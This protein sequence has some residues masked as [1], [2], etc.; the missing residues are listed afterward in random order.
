MTPH[1]SASA[2]RRPSVAWTLWL[3]SLLACSNSD[4]PTLHVQ[5]TIANWKA[6]GA[7]ILWLK[8]A[9]TDDKLADGSVTTNG[10]FQL[11]LPALGSVYMR[12]QIETGAY[13]DP[14]GPNSTTPISYSDPLYT[15]GF[16]VFDYVT[17]GNYTSYNVGSL[18][19]LSYDPR[20]P[21]PASWQSAT[22]RYFT[23]DVTISG[24][25]APYGDPIHVNL[26]F[27]SGWNLEVTQYDATSKTTTLSTVDP[28]GQPAGLQ[29][30]EFP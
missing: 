5:G 8:D 30:Y 25:C 27:K 14:C 21:K 19:L 16:G 22:Y 12:D 17:L 2:R 10:T 26:Q 4:H 11:E 28:S 23:E 18:Q 29:W 6:K 3:L 1:R 13:S 7:P 24:T 20:Q 9:Q 15:S